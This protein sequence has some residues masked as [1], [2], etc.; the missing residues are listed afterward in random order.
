MVATIPIHADIQEALADKG[1][2]WVIAALV[3]VSIGYFDPH[4]AKRTLKYYLEGERHN[5]CERCYC[6]YGADLEKMIISD[7]SDFE[8]Y[9][10]NC[11]DSFKRVMAYIA[12]WSKR[13]EEPFGGITGLM[14]PDHAP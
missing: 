9:E 11:P 3:H 4:S 1:E 7:I 14:Y 8:Y 10:A 5:M 6:L 2:N 12:A 13:P